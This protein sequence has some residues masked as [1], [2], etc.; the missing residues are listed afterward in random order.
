MPAKYPDLLPPNKTKL[1]RALAEQTGRLDGEVDGTII[2][3]LLNADECPAAYLPWLAWHMSL[4][5]W[6]W[7]WSETKRRAVIARAVELNRMKG[8]A[9]AIRTYC[10]IMDSEAVQIVVPPQEFYIGE[11]LT[12]AEW[13]VWIHQM[14][15]VR[16]K[17]IEGEGVASHDSWFVQDSTLALSD[18]DL[19]SPNDPVELPPTTHMQF[20]WI[21]NSFIL[22]DEGPILY[23]RRVIKRINGIDYPMQLVERTTYIHDSETIDVERVHIPGISSDGLFLDNDYI[24]NGFLDTQELAPKIVTIRLDGT[25]SHETSTLGLTMVWPSLKPQ[26]PRYERNSDTRPAGD[27]AYL[28]DFFMGVEDVYE[29]SP[30]G[31]YPPGFIPYNRAGDLLADRIFLIDPTVAAPMMEGM[32]F[33]GVSRL[34]MPAFRAE[35]MVDL[36]EKDRGGMIFVDDGFIN[37]NIIGT[38]DE[39][40]IDRACYAI[41]A[42]KA[43]RDK[44]MVSFAPLRPIRAT[45]ILTPEMKAGDWIAD[46]L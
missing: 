25:Y 42:S 29:T 36:L 9:H 4:D 44:I 40:L 26:S 43:V 13:D 1:E 8:T 22:D 19:D 28:D 18:I 16:I 30:L 35:V 37:D 32:S 20:G 27:Y 34:G 12:K 33:I 41:T 11:P 3:R 23:G 2:D 24:D 46:R 7:R 45:D 38:L 39:T 6:D 21:D 14:T 17:L 15:E 10:N 31:T 5:L